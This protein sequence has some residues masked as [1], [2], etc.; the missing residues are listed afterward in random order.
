MLRMAIYQLGKALTGKMDRITP[1]EKVKGM[2]YH[3]IKT[4]L[5]CGAP[6]SAFD[7]TIS[8]EQLD[9][10]RQKSEG[11]GAGILA[12]DQVACETG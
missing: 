6:K 2:T 9:S 11:D 7:W 3:Q 5:Q 12:T 4:T 10:Q 1:P 8:P